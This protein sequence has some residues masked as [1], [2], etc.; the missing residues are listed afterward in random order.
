[1]YELSKNI[2]LTTV[3]GSFLP[4]NSYAVWIGRGRSEIIDCS[5]S[6]VVSVEE[7][8]DNIISSIET[9]TTLIEKDVLP[10]IGIIVI[11]DCDERSKFLCRWLRTIYPR[12]NDTQLKQL[13]NATVYQYNC[14]KEIKTKFKKFDRYGY[15][16]LTPKVINNAPDTFVIANAILDPKWKDILK[17]RATALYDAAIKQECHSLYEE[18]FELRF[19]TAYTYTD[20]AEWICG[21]CTHRGASREYNVYGAKMEDFRKLFREFSQCLHN[22]SI[23]KLLKLRDANTSNI[24]RFIQENKRFHTLDEIVEDLT[25]PDTLEIYSNTVEMSRTSTEIELAKS[26]RDRQDKQNFV[27]FELP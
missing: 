23:D 15:Y 10:K 7:N 5:G 18:F 21:G 16:K 6:M 26:A 3:T 14:N 12:L 11:N 22:Y 4:I 25:G 24:I 9:L 20:T 13:Y 27:A 17:T 19:G 8:S 1:M 2:Y